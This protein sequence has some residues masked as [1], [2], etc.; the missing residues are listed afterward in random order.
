MSKLLNL[1][2][3][4]GDK[5]SEYMRYCFMGG[6]GAPAPP[7]NT[8]QSQTSEFPNELKPYITDILE[9]GKTRAETRDAEGYVE[10]PAPRQAEFTDNQTQSQTGIANLANNGIAGD[11]TLSSSKNYMTAALNATNNAGQQFTPTAAANYMSPYMQNV[12]DIQKREAERVGDQQQQSI[13]DQGVASGAFGGSRQAILESE[14]MR[15]ESQQMND[16]QM[17][18]QQN[19]FE[20][21]Q[22][23]FERQR[24][25]DLATGQQ[26]AGLGVQA[27]QQAMGELGAK[28]GVGAQ[29]Q[30]QNQAGLDIGYQQFQDEQQHPEQVLQEYSSLVRGFPLTSNQFASTQTATPPPNMMTQVAGLAGAG[31]AAYGAFKN[32]GGQVSNGKGIAALAEGGMTASRKRL[33]DPNYQNPIG[34]SL[35][36]L[37]GML[38]KGLIDPPTY[39]AEKGRLLVKQQIGEG[40]M[41][42][43][44]PILPSKSTEEVASR[45]GQRGRLD[46]RDKG[47][48]A[49][50][51]YKKAGP[52]PKNTTSNADSPLSMLNSAMQNPKF[53]NAPTT[54]GIPTEQQAL[55][56]L[57][58]ASPEAMLR[59]A[60]ANP[61]FV[62]KQEEQRLLKQQDSEDSGEVGGFNTLPTKPEGTTTPTKDK[63]I[64]LAEA[65]AASKENTTAKKTAAPAAKSAGAKSRI[66]EVNKIMKA[67]G[68]EEDSL[69]P[70]MKGIRNK[71]MKE[72]NTAF[73]KRKE[74]L[75]KA[76]KGVDKDRYLAAAAFFA[77]VVAQGGAGHSLLTSMGK[78]AGETG[79]FK[80]LSDMNREQREIA[81][82]L[83]TVDLERVKTAYGLS[84]DEV[85]DFERN[86]MFDLKEKEVDGA[87][88]AA[89]AKARTAKGTAAYKSAKDAADAEHKRKELIVKLSKPLSESQQK[90]W[91]GEHKDIVKSIENSYPKYEKILKGSFWKDGVGADER[92]KEQ[93][94]YEI[95]KNRV[96][97]EN[98]SPRKRQLAAFQKVYGPAI[99]KQMTGGKK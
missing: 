94:R 46:S 3:Q 67:S 79:L 61:E 1:V 52:A 21:A 50:L 93:F 13:A 29:Q 17:A 33:S 11:P 32:E 48:A 31:A 51:A 44:Q 62:K 80:Q 8:S 91:D 98:E 71:F 76:E 74:S 89:E 47:I 95:N 69:S 88:A 5:L 90:T 72:I 87:I 39:E 34:K 85:A 81:T 26:Y 30:A 54:Q 73:D 84:K 53:A 78:A 41:G 28:A 49:A 18:G 43:D 45:M 65:K 25:R 35:E 86:R 64:T 16:I 63:P 27:G 22:G 57:D 23:M 36:D 4:D 82:Q 37:A 68:V 97:H 60:Y 38:A 66:P 19:A 12:V 92:L 14:Q 96:D 9:R 6:G 83:D 7:S 40:A 24:G 58:P 42:A 15:N 70:D 55:N 75:G 2:G 56:D 20:S 59:D 99:R 10:Y 77:N